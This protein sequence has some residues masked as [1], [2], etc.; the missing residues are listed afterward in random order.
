LQRE[1]K[2]SELP[3]HIKAAAEQQNS[4]MLAAMRVLKQ[5]LNVVEKWLGITVVIA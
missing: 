2:R 4:M 5:R 1:T 3:E